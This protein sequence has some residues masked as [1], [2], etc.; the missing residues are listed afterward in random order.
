MNTGVTA[1]A[2]LLPRQSCC[3]GNPAAQAILLPRQS[4]W[5]PVHA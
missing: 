2:I 3:P 4:C 1:Q 5:D